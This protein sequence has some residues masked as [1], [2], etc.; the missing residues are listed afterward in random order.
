MDKNNNVFNKFLD[1]IKNNKGKTIL[2]AALVV[3]L[4]VSMSTA[5]YFTSGEGS[6]KN[7]V[8]GNLDITY[9]DGQT[10]KASNSIPLSDDEIEEYAARSSF[11]FR[12]TGNITLYAEI[13]LTD[14]TMDSAL[15]NQDFRWELLEEGKSIATGSFA[16]V[17]NNG[18]SLKKDIKVLVGDTSK[19]YE[20]LIWIRDN[21][22]NQNTMLNKNMSAKI[23]LK[24]TDKSVEYVDASG[25]NSPV[26]AE[27]MIPVTYDEEKDEWIKADTKSE[28][29]NYSEQKW[30]NAVTVTE[31]NRNTYMNAAEG[32]TIPM[33]DI[34]TMWVW[35][36]RYKYKIPSNIGSS[37]NVT[38]PPEIDVVFETD[39]A[40]TGVDEATYRSGMSTTN[41]N[42][43]THP[44]FRDGSKVYNTVPY[45][46]GGWDKELTGMWVGKFETSGTANTPTIKP[47]VSSLRNQNVSTQFITSLKLVGGTMNT[48]T[49]K[50]TFSGNTTY[51]LTSSTDTH[52]MKNTEWGMVAILSQ[53]KYGKMGNSDYIG[54]N[55]EVYINNSS[56]YYTGRSGGAPG[57]STPINGTYSGQTSTTQ[58]NSYGYYTYNDYL[59]NYNT[60]TKGEKVK[61]KG[62]GAST[63]GSIYGIYDMSGGA[64]EYTFGNWNG[65]SG[66][67]S[68]YNSGFNGILLNYSNTQE[69]TDGISFPEAKYYDKYTKGDESNDIPTKEKSILGDAT[70]ETMGW[71]QDYAYFPFAYY[72]FSIR[73]GN[74]SSTTDAGAF[75]SNNDF[76]DASTFSSFR[77]AL[78][79]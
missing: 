8:L 79:P 78:I 33:S 19:T 36:P 43:Y 1:I 51:G 52:M 5:I 6:N 26:L 37:S 49:G 72:P 7:F 22:G 75:Y 24:A 27:G 65:Y 58:Y 47:D 54:A 40:T 53:S 2:V 35:I 20:I 50:V 4:I 64:S 14:I 69:K 3:V 15:K 41:T 60:N 74:D 63:T 11:S 77:F 38:N 67:D 57:G 18:I 71:Y 66:Q 45:D 16:N 73:G 13:L 17:K 21:G 9:I 30:A 76:G 42:Y 29:Y 25:A 70:W 59:L 55:K 32:T 12:N 39:Y 28:W 61:G 34:N 62:T 68:S 46:I 48:S 23:T 10:I 56:S 44:A 31:T